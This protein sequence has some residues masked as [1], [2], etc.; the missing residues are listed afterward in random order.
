MEK[1]DRKTAAVIPATAVGSRK[2]TARV[3]EVIIDIASIPAFFIL[4]VIAMLYA[5]IL[6]LFRVKEEI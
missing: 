3:K 2:G 1:A 6:F 5:G 4:F